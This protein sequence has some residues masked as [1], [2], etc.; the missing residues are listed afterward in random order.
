MHDSV[1]NLGVQSLQKRKAKS[2]TERIYDVL[3]KTETVWTCACS[4]FNTAA[5]DR[6][7][8]NGKCDTFSVRVVFGVHGKESDGFQR[9]VENCTLEKNKA[10]L[11]VLSK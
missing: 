8:Y 6:R 3:C 10:F 11:R 5:N 2:K 9:K 4:N 7:R 1:G